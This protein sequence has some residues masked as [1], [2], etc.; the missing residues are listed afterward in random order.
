MSNFAAPNASAD[1]RRWP[2][3]MAAFWR[4]LIEPAALSSIGGLLVIF[5]LAF[6]LNH[7]GYY[8]LAAGLIVACTV[9]GPW[10]AI[11]LNIST[12]DSDVTRVSYITVSIV[13]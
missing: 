9:V 11:A 6:G 1:V 8:G 5:V 2:Q 10:A 7:S 3:G 4:W 12:L 13:L